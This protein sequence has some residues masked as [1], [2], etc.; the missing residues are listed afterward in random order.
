[1][2]HLAPTQT[3]STQNITS[4]VQN[5]HKFVQLVGLLSLELCTV[6]VHV[7]YGLK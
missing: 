7:G 2:G 4:N 6:N 3:F 1:M 5:K